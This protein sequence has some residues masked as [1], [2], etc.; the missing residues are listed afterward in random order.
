MA[1]RAASRSMGGIGAV[2]RSDGNR[3]GPDAACSEALAPAR[4]VSLIS[5]VVRRSKAAEVSVRNFYNPNA[6]LGLDPE[7]NSNSNGGIRCG[8]HALHC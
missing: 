2:R 8:F 5:S 3:K 7:S 4:A 6:D 1:Q